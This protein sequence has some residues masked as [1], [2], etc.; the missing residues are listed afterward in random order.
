MARY[1]NP[2]FYPPYRR[3]PSE[4]ALTRLPTLAKAGGAAWAS[5]F[6]AKPED[7]QRAIIMR[8]TTA[9]MRA[10]ARKA[11]HPEP[12]ILE[13]EVKP[14]LDGGFAVDP[15]APMPPLREEYGGDGRTLEDALREAKD[16]VHR[17]SLQLALIAEKHKARLEKLGYQIVVVEEPAERE[18]TAKP[19]RK[20]QRG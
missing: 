2:R 20:A 3:T 12:I 18:P 4:Y 10:N 15:S 1:G 8:I 14:L 7:E 11:G 19:K 16:P 13:S 6:A 9:A 5:N 17:A